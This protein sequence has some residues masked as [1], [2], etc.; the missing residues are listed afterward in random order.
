MTRAVGGGLHRRAAGAAMSMPVCGVR[1]SPLNTRRE[2]NELVR[3]PGYGRQQPSVAGAAGL[4]V[5]MR[6]LQ[7]V[8][9][10]ARQRARSC[11]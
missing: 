5:A 10:R 3:M 7:C 1:A 9:A 8:R 6:R 4:K 2:P 11:G